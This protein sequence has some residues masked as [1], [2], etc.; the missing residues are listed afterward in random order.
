L[1]PAEG[2]YDQQGVVAAALEEAEHWSVPPLGSG[3]S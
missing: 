1:L 2:K 3:M